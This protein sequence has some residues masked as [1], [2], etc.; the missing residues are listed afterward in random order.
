MT[1]ETRA[2]R[3]A[4]RVGPLIV[5][6]IVTLGLVGTL[7]LFASVLLQRRAPP[8]AAPSAPDL[9]LRTFDG[10]TYTLAGLQGKPIILNFWAS[11]CI[12][13][14]AEAP[15]L[16]KVWQQYRDR[17]LVVLG[18]DYSDNDADARKFIGEFQQTY[19]NGPDLGGRIARAYGI[20]GVS[21]TYFIDRRG[22]LLQGTDPGGR[23]KANWIGPVPEE[24]L[25]A[26]AQELL[27]P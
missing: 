18:V 17:G 14:R 1:T 16:Q 8:L 15:R 27:Q 5:F 19:P 13:C 22:Q 26:R 9:T 11:W 3:P 6:A 20:S 7:A 23:V 4:R 21:E 10:E 25:T 2:A 12:P 24:V